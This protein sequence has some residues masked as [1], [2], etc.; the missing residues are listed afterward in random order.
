MDSWIFISYRNDS[1]GGKYADLIEQ[2][3]VSQFDRSCVFRDKNSIKLASRWN[4]SIDNA[5]QK[6]NLFIALV[7]EGWNLE[8]L[9]ID[10][11]WVKREINQ[12][13]ILKK[14]ILPLYINTELSEMTKLPHEILPFLYF[15]GLHLKIDLNRSNDLAILGA[16]IKSL[17]KCKVRVISP[18]PGNRRHGEWQIFIDKNLVSI[19]RLGQES[20]FEV[21]PGKQDMMISWNEKHISTG[22]NDYEYRYFGTSNINVNFL[23]GEY[24]FTLETKNEYKNRT[25]F[26]EIRDTFKFDW[27]N[28]MQIKMST[29]I[30]MSNSL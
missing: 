2:Y 12:A 10:G 18:L 8:K 17:I 5:L 13:L 1:N 25:F 30:K 28:T 19:I 15:Q 6:S 26:Q 4:D 24:I 14:K 11:D 9:F 23:P 20:T 3:L 22:R 21:P 16:T 29:F 27:E 7:H